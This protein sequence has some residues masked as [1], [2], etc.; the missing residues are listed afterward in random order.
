M[1]G[2][3][4]VI[5]GLL[6]V[7]MYALA[8]FMFFNNTAADNS[9]NIS[10]GSDS[11]VNASLSNITNSLNS[12]GK[13]T[14]STQNAFTTSN[15]QIVAESLI[16]TS[17]GSIWKTMVNIPYVV[18][19]VTLGLIFDKIFGDAGFAVFFGLLSSIILVIIIGYA[20]A[21]IRSGIFE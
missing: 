8:M 20:W 5:I 10:I 13:D 18:Y 6:L 15:P 1:A 21:W 3:K 19:T 14:N 17:V 12:Y 7:G 9:S 16:F 11:K 4:G 2:I